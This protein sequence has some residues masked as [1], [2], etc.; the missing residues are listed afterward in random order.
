MFHQVI[1]TI[2]ANIHIRKPS[3]V[4]QT[5]QHVVKLYLIRLRLEVLLHEVLLDRSA[6]ACKKPQILIAIHIFFF[7]TAHKPNLIEPYKF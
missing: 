5:F 4:S 1:K 6:F 7:F 3:I 2:L